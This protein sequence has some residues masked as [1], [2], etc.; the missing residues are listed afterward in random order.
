M[1]PEWLVLEGIETGRDT[2]SFESERGR[3]G[4]RGRNVGQEG[5]D[6][7]SWEESEA[8]SPCQ[9]MAIDSIT[10]RRT[11]GRG[12]LK[13]PPTCRSGWR[14]EGRM[15][16]SPCGGLSGKEARTPRESGG[17]YLKERGR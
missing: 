1:R 6:P 4:G 7:G 14:R 13:E 10:M 2:W 16:E 5:Q 8:L 11:K 9:P 17:T 15:A 3:G 12:L